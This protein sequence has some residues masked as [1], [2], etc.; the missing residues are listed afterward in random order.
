MEKNMNYLVMNANDNQFVDG[1]CSSRLEA[2]RRFGRCNTVKIK[3]VNEVEVNYLAVNRNDGLIE[4]ICP[5]TLEVACR[6]PGCRAMTIR[7]MMKDVGSHMTYMREFNNDRPSGV[8]NEGFLGDWERQSE[9]SIRQR[10]TI[11][12]CVKLSSEWLWSEE[13]QKLNEIPRF[14]RLAYQ[15]KQTPIAEGLAYL[16]KKVWGVVDKD[17]LTKAEV[18]RSYLKEFGLISQAWSMTSADLHWLYRNAREVA[19]V[20][21]DD[22]DIFSQKELSVVDNDEAEAW[23]AFVESYNDKVEEESGKTLSVFKMG[24]GDVVIPNWSKESKGGKEVADKIEYQKNYPWKVLDRYIDALSSAKNYEELK[25]LIPGKLPMSE[26]IVSFLWGWWIKE[27][28]ARFFCPIPWMK[29]K[30]LSLVGVAWE[31]RILE[32]K[33][34]LSYKEWIVK[35]KNIRRELMKNKSMFTKFDFDSLFKLVPKP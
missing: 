18:L 31:K 2:T 23:I 7:T 32:L 16:A 6:F 30:S 19:P 29:V 33:E 17:T 15:D 4:G 1:V 28:N 21:V 5:S 14:G 9:M 27:R 25:A 22:S 10:Q 20:V 11:V 34:S 24:I 12:D 13:K 8:H 35:V 26:K 3:A